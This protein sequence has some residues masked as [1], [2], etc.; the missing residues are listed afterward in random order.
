MTRP[1]RVAQRSAHRAGVAILTAA[2]LGAVV[3]T[4][5]MVGPVLSLATG[6]VDAGSLPERIRACG[7]D[8]RVSPG[9]TWSIEGATARD[10]RLRLVVPGPLGFTACPTQTGAV[11]TALFVRVGADAVAVYELVGGP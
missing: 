4:A 8:Y 3:M 6:I 2:A 5:V 10:G 9:V 7:R 1:S 11:T